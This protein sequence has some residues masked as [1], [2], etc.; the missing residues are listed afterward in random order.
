MDAADRQVF[1]AWVTDNAPGSAFCLKDGENEECLVSVMMNFPITKLM[2]TRWI[3]G[4]LVLGLWSCKPSESSKPAAATAADAAVVTAPATPRTWKQVDWG[5]PVEKQLYASKNVF[6]Q[7][8]PSWDVEEWISKK[9]ELTN[10]F[11][12]IDF[13][14]TWCGPC[15]VAIKELNAIAKEFPEDLVVIGIS[16]EPAERVRAMKEPQIEY[17]SAVDTKAKLKT[18]LGITGIPH[19]LLID[20]AGRVCWQ[21]FPLSEEDKLT[22]KVVAERIAKFKAAQ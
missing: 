13:W 19:V 11:V 8:A 12:L 22:A 2:D 14:A 5:K 17:F 18:E 15:R 3:A 6:N 16:H 4:M 21:G 7:A 1:S 10:K 9:P 20:P